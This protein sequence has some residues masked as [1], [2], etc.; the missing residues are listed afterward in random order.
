M[1]FLQRITLD[2]SELSEADKEEFPFN[3]RPIRNQ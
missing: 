2:W 1:P 3:I